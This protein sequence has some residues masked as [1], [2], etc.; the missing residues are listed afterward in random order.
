MRASVGLDSM[1]KATELMYE[2]LIR[3][4]LNSA[5][6]VLL[7]AFVQYGLELTCLGVVQLLMYRVGEAWARG[8]IPVSVEHH[9]SLFV[10]GKL[11]ERL[12]AY[13][14]SGRLGPEVAA[15]RPSA[16]RTLRRT[17]AGAQ[18]IRGAPIRHTHCSGRPGCAIP[19]QEC[20]VVSPILRELGDKGAYESLWVGILGTIYAIPR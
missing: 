12:T 7:Q 13:E 17:N 2:A 20:L 6:R 16:T 1:E 3:L 9:A 8:D 4:D 14:H 18:F 19:V 5:G 15:A 10:R 11:A